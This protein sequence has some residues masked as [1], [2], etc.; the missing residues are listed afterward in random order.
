MQ[1]YYKENEIENIIELINK[2]KNL[3]KIKPKK[4]YT[5][6]LNIMKNMNISVF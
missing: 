2:S 4:N 5:K 1:E 3:I 6:K